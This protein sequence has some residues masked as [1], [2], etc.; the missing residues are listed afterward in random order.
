[1]AI[2]SLH[3]EPLLKLQG[4]FSCIIKCPAY[5][6][7]KWTVFVS[8]A[9]WVSIYNL[10][11]MTYDLLIEHLLIRPTGKKTKSFKGTAHS[12]QTLIIYTLT[13]QTA[14]VLACFVISRINAKFK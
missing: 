3:I 12:E 10:I 7:K 6:L 5:F 13:Q 8:G 1:M 4:F 9:H 11:P 14:L 2:C